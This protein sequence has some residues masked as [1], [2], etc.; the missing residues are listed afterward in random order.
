M[1]K[2]WITYLFFILG[3]LIITPVCY[4]I[5]ADTNTVTVEM[6]DNQANDG[7][8]QEVKRL[9]DDDIHMELLSLN[10]PQLIA[11][12]SND[13]DLFE[14]LPYISLALHYPPPNQA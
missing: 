9:L 8:E 1:G 12:M 2:H 14:K 11:D 13:Q 7:E 5:C 3:I 4:L 6:S 10:L